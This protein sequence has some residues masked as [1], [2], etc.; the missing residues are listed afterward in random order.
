MTPDHAFLHAARNL[1]PRVAHTL[2]LTIRQL[3]ASGL[4]AIPPAEA[5]NSEIRQYIDKYYQAKMAN[6]EERIKLFKLAWDFVGSS[7]G[8][9]QDLYEYFFFG[10]P[11]RMASNLYNWYTRKDEYKKRVKDFLDNIK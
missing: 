10:D 7:F 1:W 8:S 9:R 2:N 5:L 6:A 11:F 3:G 4:M